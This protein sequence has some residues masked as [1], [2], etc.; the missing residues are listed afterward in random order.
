MFDVVYDK[1]ALDSVSMVIKQYVEEAEQE[2]REAGQVDTVH[3]NRYLGRT[4]CFFIV[5][6]V[7][8][9]LV[10]ILIF[11]SPMYTFYSRGLFLSDMLLTSPQMFASEVHRILKPGGYFII[12]SCNNSKEELLEL[13]TQPPVTAAATT[14]TT[15]GDEDNGLFVLV[16]D[17]TDLCR[18]LRYFIFQKRK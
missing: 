7:F 3:D 18:D 9:T 6:V 10:F 13:F 4:Y 17:L 15:E 16:S 2:G 8:I 1:G 12:I 5:C 11:F 14:A